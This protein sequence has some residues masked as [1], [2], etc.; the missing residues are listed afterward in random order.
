MSTLHKT[1]E[2]AVLPQYSV[3]PFSGP[4]FRK[5]EQRLKEGETPCVICG[6]A[7]AYPYAHSAV[8]VH[9]G[10]WASSVEDAQN[11]ADS[12]YMGVWGIGP[13]CHKKFLIRP[14]V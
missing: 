4:N 12:G 5:N 6:K 9:G 13:D 2:K 10:S 1:S 7:V 8:V 3:D 11:E 14:L